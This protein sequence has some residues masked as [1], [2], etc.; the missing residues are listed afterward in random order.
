MRMMRLITK[1]ECV[2][3][4]R[5]KIAYPCI[6][7]GCQNF[8]TKCENIPY[9]RQVWIAQLNCQPPKPQFDT[10]MVQVPHFRYRFNRDRSGTS[11]KDV[12]KLADPENH[13]GTWI[14]KLS[15]I[16]RVS[17]NTTNGRAHNN[18]TTCC[19]TNSPPTDKNLP[20]PNILTCR[21]VGLWHCDVSNLLYN[22]LQ[23]CCE[24]VRWWCCT[25]CP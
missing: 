1:L 11:L 4:S 5:L 14:S 8:V 16:K 22:K 23:N 9:R 20:H 24:L 7:D 21:D 6:C 10:W 12:I 17:A 15:H 25:K 3:L 2:A 13:F 19:T 18:S